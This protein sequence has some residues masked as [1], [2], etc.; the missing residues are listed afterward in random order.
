MVTVAQPATNI[1]IDTRC[2]RNN[3][4][5]WPC[6]ERLEAMRTELID[7]PSPEKVA[8]YNKALWGELPT[9][10]LGQ[11]LQPVAWRKVIS[12][13]PISPTLVFWNVRKRQ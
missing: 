13:L 1:L 6:S 3:Y 2:D 5:G 12:G 7:A 9:I 8:E 4:V 11:Y 10:L